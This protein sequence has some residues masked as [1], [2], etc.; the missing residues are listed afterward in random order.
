MDVTMAYWG[1]GGAGGGVHMGRWKGERRGRRASACGHDGGRARVAGWGRAGEGLGR[2]HGTH[3]ECGGKGRGAGAGAAPLRTGHARG[4]PA[5]PCWMRPALVPTWRPAVSLSDG[6]SLCFQCIVF[7][8]GGLVPPVYDTS[9]F[10]ARLSRRGCLWNYGADIQHSLSVGSPSC[11]RC[12]GLDQRDERPIRA[13]RQPQ[14]RGPP[15]GPWRGGRERKNC[16]YIPRRRR[17]GTR[18]PRRPPAPHLTPPTSP[19]LSPPP[20]LAQAAKRVAAGERS[21]GEHPRVMQ[22]P[23]PPPKKRAAY[24]QD[25]TPPRTHTH[26]H[27]HT[28]QRHPAHPIPSPPLPPPRRRWRGHGRR[29]GPRTA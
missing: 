14:V 3:C 4:A 12:G 20:P 7:H 23:P 26:T 29:G 22:P 16:L 27:A 13:H 28:K 25:A 5:S 1:G 15:R 21:R 2:V 8:S 24:T 11:T 9:L 10:W 19:P 6:C 18:P 17:P